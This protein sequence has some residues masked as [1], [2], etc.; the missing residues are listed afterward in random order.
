[1]KRQ[2]GSLLTCPHIQ[3][4]IQPKNFPLTNSVH[5]G[6]SRKNKNQSLL[7]TSLYSQ[8][9]ILLVLSQEEPF[10]HWIP[11][12]VSRAL[13]WKLTTWPPWFHLKNHLDVDERSRCSTL[14]LWRKKMPTAGQSVDWSLPSP[15]STLSSLVEWMWAPYCLY[16]CGCWHKCKEF[17]QNEINSLKL[18]LSCVI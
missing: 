16:L 8:G 9:C 2:G 14:F 15:V 4:N 12:Q 1:M 11:I 18:S 7:D 5:L 10:N 3:A 17:I 13:N 6:N